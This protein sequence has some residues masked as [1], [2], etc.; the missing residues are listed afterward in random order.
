MFKAKSRPKNHRKQEADTE[1]QDAT[2][3]ADDAPLPSG[4]NEPQMR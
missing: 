2:L 1:G 3:Q 4:K